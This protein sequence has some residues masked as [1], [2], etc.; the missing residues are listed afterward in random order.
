MT[1]DEFVAH[2]KEHEPEALE[3]LAQV[4]ESKRGWKVDYRLKKVGGGEVPFEGAELGHAGRWINYLMNWFD[5]DQG[6]NYWERIC[7]RNGGF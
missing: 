6:P 5:T 2:I 3:S 1:F 4:Y 7:M